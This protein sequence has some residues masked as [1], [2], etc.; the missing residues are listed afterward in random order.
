MD[1]VCVGDGIKLAH[2][3]A[4][5]FN[6]TPEVDFFKNFGTAQIKIGNDS[7]QSSTFP[8]SGDRAF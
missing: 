2:K 5:Q 6:P 4:A 3:V 8:P 7:I 1:I